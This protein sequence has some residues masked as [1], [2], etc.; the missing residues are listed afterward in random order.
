MKTLPT[1]KIY[2][3][4]HFPTAYRDFKARYALAVINLANAR[5]TMER[6]DHYTHHRQVMFNPIFVGYRH[7]RLGWL[8]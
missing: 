5:D 4:F 2:L 7:V 6:A 1:V 3:Q 8:L